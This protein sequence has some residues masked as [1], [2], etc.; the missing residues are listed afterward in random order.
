MKTVYDEAALQTQIK[1]FDSLFDVDH[2]CKQQ[3]KANALLT[4]KE[5]MRN[6]HDKEAFKILHN[7]SS[8]SL[9][10][11]GYN[12]IHMDHFCTPIFAVNRQ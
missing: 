8:R 1:Y 2:A 9:K 7:L 11:N 6:V 5:F 4:E 12:W 3:L 10:R